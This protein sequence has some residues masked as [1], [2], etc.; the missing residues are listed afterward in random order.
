MR[1]LMTA[2]LAAVAGALG[3]F[4]AEPAAKATVTVDPARIVGK[5]K[6]MNATNN[7]PSVPPVNGDQK[8]GNFTEFTWLRIPYARTHDSINIVSG[9]AHCVDVGAIFP[10]FDADETDP[11]NYDFVFTDWYFDALRKAGCEI[12]LRLGET[13]EH[14]PRKYKVLP[15]KDFKKWARICERIV[16]HY[17]EGWGWNTHTERTCRNLQWSNRFNIKY[18]EIWN[19]PDLDYYDNVE[20]NLTPRCWGGT[21]T[22]Y[23]ELYD[24]SSKHLKKRFPKM[25]IGGPALAWYEDYAERFLKW[26]REHGDPL[27]F[28]SWH[29]YARTP[30]KF[31]EKCRTMRRLLDKYG[32]QKTESIL[33]EWNYVKGWGDDYVYSRRCMSGDQ[34]LFGAA[35][36]S[37]VMNRCQAAPVDMLMYYDARPSCFN[38]MF[39]GVTKW[40]MKGYYPFY[41]WAKLRDDYG[42]EVACTVE[43]STAEDVKAVTGFVEK[44]D[45]SAGGDFSAVAA[46][47]G[48]GK[49]AVFVARFSDDRNVTD[50][51]TLV[52]RIPGRKITKGC[53]HVT[54]LVR[55][56]TEVPLEPQDDGS[57][58]L[59]MQPLS[60]ALIEL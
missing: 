12:F 60:F 47:D 2:V 25:K 14:G 9:G 46:K 37:A 13:I 8:C 10:N 17:N 24:I 41:A 38:G 44:K 50:T 40:P 45:K 21:V 33:N 49:L 42:L 22:N 48:A 26:T 32:Y 6:A 54:D 16:M 18:C 35:F 1:R 3:A 39:D 56:Y 30:E 59:A 43:D 5:I 20:S 34:V 51:G 4:A 52:L 58:V 15:P 31:V 36:V 11:K 57:A 23:F 27:D 53:A 7:G 28:Y 19:E 29:L 55:S